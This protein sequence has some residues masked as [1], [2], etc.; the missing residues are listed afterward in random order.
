MP[1]RVNPNINGVYGE[2]IQNTGEKHKKSLGN[3]AESIF[4]SIENACQSLHIEDFTLGNLYNNF[5]NAVKEIVDKITTSIAKFIYDVSKNIINLVKSNGDSVPDKRLALC[6]SATS[7]VDATSYIQI[8]EKNRLAYHFM[9]D[10]RTEAWCAD[11]VKTFVMNIPGIDSEIEDEI[12]DI[13]SV[14]QW[15]NWAKG[16]GIYTET[17][18]MKSSKRAE[19]IGSSVKPGDIMIQKRNDVSHTGLVV[20]V[21]PDGYTDPKTGKVYPA[22]SFKT[23]EGNTSNK[24]AYRIYSPNDKYLSGF[25]DMSRFLDNND[26]PTLEMKKIDGMLLK[27]EEENS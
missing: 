8:N 5:C 11:T 10:N 16:K 22:G 6:E 15:Q 4:N 24:L 18:R 1:E 9:S 23:V 17:S 7:M 13:R 3:K 27:S 20:E 12:K 26:V 2:I 14:S 25:I 19:Y 21:Y